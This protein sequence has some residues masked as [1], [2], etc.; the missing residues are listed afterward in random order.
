MQV[1]RPD[2]LAVLGDL[3]ALTGHP[4]QAEQQ[5]QTVEFSGTL[6][7]L[8]RQVYNRQLA[9]FSADHGRRRDDAVRLAQGELAERKD[10]F[11]YDTYA[12]TLLAAGRADDACCI[13]PG[14]D[15]RHSRRSDPLSRRHDRQGPG[16]SRPGAP[17][18]A[19]PR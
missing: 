6:A 1:P 13:R 12:W 4:R 10:G 14:V 8:N 18:V 9:V 11:G 7:A 15:V 19:R 16:R 2:F 5:Y 3:L 17:G